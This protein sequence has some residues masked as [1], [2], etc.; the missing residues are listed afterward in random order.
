MSYLDWQLRDEG[1]VD[2]GEELVHVRLLA[3]LVWFVVFVVLNAASTAEVAS[4]ANT[5]LV[6]SQHRQEESDLKDEDGCDAHRTVDAKGTQRR[7]NLQPTNQV[8][9]LIYR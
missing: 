3:A 5:T 6:E 1:S 7:E 8:R 2:V 4:L 9:R